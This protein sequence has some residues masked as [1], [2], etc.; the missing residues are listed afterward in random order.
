MNA[1]PLIRELRQAGIQITVTGDRLHIE[2]PTGAITPEL[3]QRIAEN[4]VELLAELRQPVTTTDTRADL[5]ALAGRLAV[6]RAH[7][8]RLDDDGVALLAAIGEGGMRS[9][10]LAADDAATRQAG[11]V[12]LDN[13]AAIYCV[14]CGPV[15]V[16]PGIA[17]VLPVVAGWPR[18]AGCPW[19]SIRKA[20][21]YVPRPRITCE[22]CTRFKPDTIN[23]AAGVGTCASGHS[24]HY[25]MQRHGCGDHRPVT[26][27]GTSHD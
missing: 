24:T 9:F 23:P 8:H 25:P 5:L 7:V 18:A 12:P 21:G 10:L 17:D 15:F 6:D 13:T 14:H 16:H 26:P 1:A 2:A 19:C 20:G 27:E 4:K 11:K 22:S 3:R